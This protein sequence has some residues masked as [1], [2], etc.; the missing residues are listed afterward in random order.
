MC[1]RQDPLWLRARARAG[2]PAPSARFCGPFGVRRREASQ[3]VKSAWEKLEWL[4]LIRGNLEDRNAG[5]GRVLIA[6]RC[7]P[8]GSSWRPV[9]GGGPLS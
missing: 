9:R 8:N 4:L 7:G 2:A 6:Q 1:G 3:E 5:R